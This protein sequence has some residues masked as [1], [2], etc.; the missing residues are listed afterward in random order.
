MK[1]KMRNMGEACAAA[2]RFFVHRSVVGEFSE[3]FAKKISEL[4]V[5]NGAVE[6]TGAFD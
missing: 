4:R 3:K 2:N 6:G 1:A 5:G